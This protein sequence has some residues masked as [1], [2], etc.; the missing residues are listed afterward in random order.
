MTANRLKSIPTG[1]PRSVRIIKIPKNQIRFIRDL[2]LVGLN[3]LGNLKSMLVRNGAETECAQFLKNENS[4]I[5]DLSR[6]HLQKVDSSMKLLPSLSQ[7]HMHVNKIK[8]FPTD[9]PRSLQVLVL[10]QNKVRSIKRNSLTMGSNL[11]QPSITNRFQ[12]K[13]RF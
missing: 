2:D 13:N 4:E 9:L 12:A 6:N 7:L 11:N 3:N 5:L 10:E 1:L 8:V